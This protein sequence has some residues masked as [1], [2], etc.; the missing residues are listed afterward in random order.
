MIVLNHGDQMFKNHETD[1]IV[2][3]GNTVHF[4]KSN[5]VICLLL[6]NNTIFSKIEILKTVC[7]N[8]K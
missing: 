8:T 5:C 7:G 3:S 2:W 4:E 6:K 1:S